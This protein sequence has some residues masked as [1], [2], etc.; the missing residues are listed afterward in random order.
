MTRLE[1]VRAISPTRAG[2]NKSKWD[3]HELSRPQATKV[4]KVV[5]DSIVAA[6][7]N[8]EKVV[9]PIGKFE[10]LEHA[11][12]PQRRWL[13]KRVRVTYA[14]RKF[15]EFTPSDWLTDQGL[16]DVKE[17]VIPR[18]VRSRDPKV[19]QRK[20]A[21]GW[22]PTPKMRRIMVFLLAK[23][24]WSNYAIAE[25]IGCDE[26]TIRRDLKFLRTPKDQRPISKRRPKK[27]RRLTRE[28][29]LKQMLK[30]SRGWIVGQGLNR[31]DVLDRLLP[32]AGRSLFEA[33]GHINTL[34]EYALRPAELLLE[35]RPSNFRDN[36]KPGDMPEKLAACTGWFIRWMAYC[37]P[38]DE[39]L[40][41][42]VLGALTRWAE[43][44]L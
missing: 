33:R 39:T 43:V 30:V 41:D 15:V 42:E 44:S 10:V 23:K 3:P 4:V 11:R 21:D 19:P 2:N 27:L 37:A 26:A 6:L 40:R 5:F 14:K 35:T 18:I 29:S 8:G 24:D 28:Q 38:R 12:P 1:L 25:K 17:R 9:L 34:P 32:D 20:S 36:Y 22:K 31:G 13:L 16:G 7:R